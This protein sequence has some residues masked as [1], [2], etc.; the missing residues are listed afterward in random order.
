MARERVDR[1]LREMS[2]KAVKDVAQKSR[3]RLETALD[4]VAPSPS[5]ERRNAGDGDSRPA[6]RP[7]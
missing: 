3:A 1:L 7:H 6:S 5:T 4:Q 2:D